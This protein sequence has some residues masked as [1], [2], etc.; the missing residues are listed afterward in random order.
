MPPR[1]GPGGRADRP[2]RADEAVACD[3]TEDRR[4]RRTDEGTYEEGP[5]H[6]L[7]ELISKRC[8]GLPGAAHA[9]AHPAHALVEEGR[10]QLSDDD[11]RGDGAEHGDENVREDEAD[12]EALHVGLPSGSRRNL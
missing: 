9:H 10:R 2:E 6:R 7:G 3:D 11:I 1:H 5:V 4:G 12:A 8:P